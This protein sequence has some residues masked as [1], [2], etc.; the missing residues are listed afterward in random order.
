MHDPSRT[1]PPRK[2]WNIENW[3]GNTVNAKR[4]IA[5][6][7]LT[8]TK[9]LKTF[10][11]VRPNDGSPAEHQEV[12]FEDLRSMNIS[13]EAKTVGEVEQ[14]SIVSLEVEYVGEEPR[15][16]HVIWVGD[17]KRLKEKVFDRFDADVPIMVEHES[18]VA[19]MLSASSIFKKRREAIEERAAKAKTHR[20]L[21]IV[22]HHRFFLKLDED[23]NTNLVDLGENDSVVRFGQY[24]GRRVLRR[25]VYG[26][27]A[28]VFAP[29]VA[30]TKEHD[31]QYL[32]DALHCSEVMRRSFKALEVDGRL[33][34]TLV[35][36]AF[37]DFLSSVLRLET[38]RKDTSA[39]GPDGIFFLSFLESI[40]YF[41]CAAETS[42]DDGAKDLWK[43]WR[44]ALLPLYLASEAYVRLYWNGTDRTKSSYELEPWRKPSL[45]WAEWRKLI[46]GHEFESEADIEHRFT[47]L[48]GFALWRSA[49]FDPVYEKTYGRHEKV[50]EETGA[51]RSAGSEIPAVNSW[52]FGHVQVGNPDGRL[53]PRAK[54]PTLAAAV[55]AAVLAYAAENERLG[56]L[57]VRDGVTADDIK[58]RHEL[59]ARTINAH[60]ES[61]TV[62][63]DLKS[64]D[65]RRL[66]PTRSGWKKRSTAAFGAITK[67][68][69]SAAAYVGLIASDSER[70]FLAYE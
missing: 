70:E 62:Q 61:G 42:D 8:R 69:G 43:Y 2:S 18:A 51:T 37:R 50:P 28:Q 68:D 41:R 13:I 6:L 45:E 35:F 58:R 56:R 1:D 15:L 16:A 17:E 21:E 31:A 52:V 57:L 29:P 22:R 12:D 54:W 23:T 44:P 27:R 59:T 7:R 34:S 39:G 40:L 9:I 20:E 67:A 55:K 19:E 63:E 47:V 48:V 60:L 46:S 24:L 49:N 65:G 53:I 66:A 64:E 11:G 14:E 36:L 38:S 10:V 26:K 33:N 25:A 5:S 3:T 30:A 32:A 4:F